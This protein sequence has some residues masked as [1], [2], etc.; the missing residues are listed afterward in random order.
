[1]TIRKQFKLLIAFIIAIPVICTTFL[2][3]QNYLHSS[4]RYLLK[5]YTSLDNLEDEKKDYADGIRIVSLIPNSIQATLIATETS[6]IICNTIPELNNQKTMYQSWSL[7]KDTYQDYYYQFTCPKTEKDTLLITRIPRKHQKLSAPEK[8]ITT[9]L[10]LFAIGIIISIVS[11]FI[12]SKTIFNSIIEIKNKTKEI[13]NGSLD[14]EI[15]TDATVKK[16]NEIMS[17]LE[18]LEKMRQS[19]CLAESRK[20]N[21]IMGISH[22]LRTPVAI[23]KGYSE[24]ISDGIINTKDEIDEAINL[25]GNKTE[26]LETMIDDLIN[27]TKLNNYEIKEQLVINSITDLIKIFAK[28]AKLSTTVYKREVICNIDLP[29]N[30][31]IPLNKKLILRALQNLFVNALRYTNDGDKIFINAHR[32]KQNILLEIKDT[33]IGINKKDLPQIFDLFYRSSS[34]R[35]EN[36]MGIGLAIV[37]NVLDAHGWTISVNSTKGVGTSFIIKIPVIENI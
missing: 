8:I 6:E 3:I 34:S 20:N 11:I 30:I 17:I 9:L 22:D 12:I 25:I 21:F 33:G 28:E 23:I 32:E 19:L 36:S 7:L 14:K 18:S 27:F 13:A 10:V 2:L 16:Q 15:K 35:R 29:E 1:M 5:E 24:A 26:Q 4:K 31:L 37:K